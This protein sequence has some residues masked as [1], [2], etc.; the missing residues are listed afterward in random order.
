MSETNWLDVDEVRALRE[1]WESQRH[2]CWP[3][4]QEKMAKAIIWL[5]ARAVVGEET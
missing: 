5:V 4:E 2:N 1:R 3:I